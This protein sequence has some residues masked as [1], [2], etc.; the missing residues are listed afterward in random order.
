MTVCRIRVIFDIDCFGTEQ[1]GPQL[2]GTIFRKDRRHS[3]C[4]GFRDAFLK[5][6]RCGGNYPGY[7]SSLR[8]AVTTM[9]AMPA[10]PVGALRP[11]DE[12]GSWACAKPEAR[13][14]NALNLRLAAQQDC[15]FPPF[16]FSW[17]RVVLMCVGTRAVPRS[18]RSGG[19]RSA[20]SSRRARRPRR[21][22]RRRPESRKTIAFSRYHRAGRRGRLRKLVEM[23][24][25]LGRGVQLGCGGLREHRR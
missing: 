24:P 22:R 13:V 10:C 16:S 21:C 20:L 18:I 6:L 23:G 2:P 17:P 15:C 8:R 25:A 3:R 7:S 12:G 1:R 19:G 11:P 4:A 9:S 14:M 5:R